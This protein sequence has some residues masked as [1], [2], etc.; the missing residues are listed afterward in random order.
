MQILNRCLHAFLLPSILTYD[1][2]T[3]DQGNVNNILF[4]QENR[5]SLAHED[6]SDAQ[7]DNPVET[8]SGNT[9]SG[10]MVPEAAEDELPSVVPVSEISVQANDEPVDSLPQTISAAAP[11]RV[12]LSHELPTPPLSD[13]GEDMEHKEPSAEASLEASS[14][15]ADSTEVSEA[16]KEVKSSSG[17]TSKWSRPG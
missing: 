16:S 8:P 3:D 7:R 1:V 6:V 17:S 10:N 15:P 2:A 11:A 9:D 14:G 4:I 5:S 13:Q 12:T